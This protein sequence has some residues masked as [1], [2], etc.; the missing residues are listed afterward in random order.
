MSGRSA[1]AQRASTPDATPAASSG[2]F[3]K[4]LVRVLGI[5]VITLA[6]LWFL[7]SHFTS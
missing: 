7:Q 6:L 2:Q 3:T 1:K 5:Q 4:T